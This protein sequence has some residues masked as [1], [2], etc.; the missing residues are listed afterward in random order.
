MHVTKV[1]QQRHK[2]EGIFRTCVSA[3]TLWPFSIIVVAMQLVV[4]TALALLLAVAVCCAPARAVPQEDVKL[5]SA[6]AS[7]L[8]DPLAPVLAPLSA[9]FGAD[10]VKTWQMFFT[11]TAVGKALL[12]SDASTCLAN[13]NGAKLSD[14]LTAALATPKCS[15]LRTVGNLPFVRDVISNMTAKTELVGFT[16]LL[17]NVSSDEY[18]T[19]CSLYVDQVVPCVNMELLPA[20]A[21]LRAKFASGCCDAW[22]TSAVRDFSYSVSDLVTKVAQLAG[23][24]ACSRQTPSFLGNASQPCAYTFAQTSLR[25]ND[26]ATLGADLIVNLQVPT[27]Q[28]CLQAEGKA[29]VDVN[30]AKVAA[31]TAPSAS[32]CVVALDRAAS[33]VAALP[34]AQRTNAFDI[35]TLF[36]TT[37]CLKGS[38]FFPIVRDFFPSSVADV[39]GAYFSKACVH[40]PI[41]YADKCAYSRTASLVDWVS[42]PAKVKASDLGGSS[43]SP[44]SKSNPTSNILQTKAPVDASAATGALHHR[45]GASRYMLA[46]VAVVVGVAW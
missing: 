13:L 11:D 45:L 27:D 36:A 24:V 34:L 26:S 33:W 23:D 30:G 41:K 8:S 10:A 1:T 29:Y 19:F 20:I 15:A 18:E 7:N 16:K 32:G 42:E 17:R 14:A 5:V 2:S 39:V 43:S 46:L 28:M 38:E 35:P 9:T 3:L 21:T 40:V 37:A 4:R 6:C 44:A 22:A 31:A 25:A 12:S